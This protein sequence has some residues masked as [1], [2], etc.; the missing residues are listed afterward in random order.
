MGGLEDI[1]NEAVD[2]V[3]FLSPFLF[4]LFLVLFSDSCYYNATC[5]S[6][7]Q[8]RIPVDEVFRELNC[9]KEGLTNEEGQKRLQVFG[10]NKLEEKEAIIINSFIFFSLKLNLLMCILISAQTLCFFHRS[11]KQTA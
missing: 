1:K 6:V 11:G 5:F 9:S 10:P 7:L 3:S 4:L 2:L 8:E